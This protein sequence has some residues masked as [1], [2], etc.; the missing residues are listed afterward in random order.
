MTLREAVIKRVNELCDEENVAMGRL[1][2]NGYKTPTT[3]YDFY[4]GR[5]KMLKLDTVKAICQGAN[6]TLQKFF[7]PAYFNDYEEWN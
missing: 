6:V 3:Y 5:T 1:C 7:E 4:H 2:L